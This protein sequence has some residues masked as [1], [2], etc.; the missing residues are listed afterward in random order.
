MTF[1]LE[2]PKY[3]NSYYDTELRFSLA[4]NTLFVF[5]SNLKGYHGAGAAKDAVA[6]FGAIMGKA[7]GLQGNSYAIPTKSIW[8][9]P[10][11]IEEIRR[12]ILRFV[13]WSLDNE[14]K[15]FITAVGTGYSRVPHSIIAPMFKDVKNAWLPQQWKQLIEKAQNEI[16]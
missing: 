16:S 8:L 4:P 7:E 2:D 3:E 15:Y 12:N 10:L 5:G 1:E 9:K 6:E 11:P 14:Y 13:G